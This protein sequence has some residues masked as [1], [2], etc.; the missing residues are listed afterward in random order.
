MAQVLRKSQNCDVKFAVEDVMLI[1]ESHSVAQDVCSWY[2]DDVI[3]SALDESACE[4]KQ[5][6]G[7][8]R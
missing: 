4:K 1:Y 8:L 6:N 7:P 5:L 2:P 3:K